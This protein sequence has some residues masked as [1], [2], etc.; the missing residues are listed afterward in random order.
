MQLNNKLE[1]IVEYNKLY[2]SY[3]T[4]YPPVG[5]WTEEF[6]ESNNYE[7]VMIKTFLVENNIRN[8][9]SLYIHFP[10]C[11][12]QCYF[13]HCHTI[14]SKD[15]SKFVEF[16]NVLEK[17]ISIFKE[18]V[19]R[20]NISINI[21]DIH[22]GGG[23][24]SGMSKEEFKYLK[25]ILS[26]IVEFDKITEFSIEIDVRYTNIER[27]KAFAEDGIT[28]ISFGVQD[29]NEKVQQTINRVQS[30]EVF[31]D[32]LPKVKNMFRGINF[33]LIYGMPYQTIESFKET[34][35]NVVKLNPDRIALYKYNHK[36]DLYKHQ[37]FIKNDML[38]SEEDNIKINYYAIE[39]LLYHGY[40]RVG[41]DHFAKRTDNL[42]ISALNSEVKRNFMGYTAGEYSRTIGF[43]P[44]S[45]SDLYG[46]YVQNTYD[47][48]YYNSVINKGML[49]IFRG[50]TLTKDD[51]VR[52]E[53]IYGI[54]NNFGVFY[55]DIERSFSIDF[56][57]YFSSELQKLEII[58]NDGLVIL[59]ND[60]FIVTEIGKYCLRN[61]AIIFDAIYACS[62]EYKYSKD[63]SYKNKKDTVS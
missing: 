38:P 16:L 52:R 50:Y 6:V 12:S 10:F 56:L 45:M 7:D 46:Y 8:N 3:Y 24:P 25:D 19:K 41:I 44:S 53:V 37:Q 35:L 9:V 30:Y 58:A 21:V 13:C 29:F 43:G 2:S 48:N 57:S 49:P 36:P 4:N 11:N 47:M 51:I 23:S 55:S 1:K 26:N 5:E 40:I 39:Q 22:L 60:S 17:E 34:I 15:H 20:N 28:R 42:G 31:Q 62:N 54:M 59:N 61:I 33:D 14:I 27:I 63:F 32:L 18:I